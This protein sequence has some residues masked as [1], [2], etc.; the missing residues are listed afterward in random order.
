MKNVETNGLIPFPFLHFLR[1]QR[2]SFFFFLN[3][4]IL[5]QRGGREEMGTVPKKLQA[6]QAAKLCGAELES[7]GIQEEN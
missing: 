3:K 7:L 5:N 1:M 4:N 6:A 2:E